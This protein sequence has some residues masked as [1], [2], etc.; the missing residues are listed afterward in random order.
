MEGMQYRS[1][2][3]LVKTGNIVWYLVM[4]KVAKVQSQT[5]VKYWQVF[6]W[7]YLENY[8]LQFRTYNRDNKEWDIYFF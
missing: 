1:N 8:H 4:A 6:N 7:K 2:L 3:L 5:E